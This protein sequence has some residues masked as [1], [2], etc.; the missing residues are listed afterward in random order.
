MKKI[1]FSFFFLMVIT[2]LTAM[3]NSMT[4][5]TSRVSHYPVEVATD[6]ASTP[7]FLC[8]TSDDLYVNQ[9]FADISDVDDFDE[10]A[11]LK[12]DKK[13]CLYRCSFLFRRFSN[14]FFSRK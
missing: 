4:G 3:E 7:R 11:G 10:E 14:T 5:L 6:T 8:E 1:F 12:R 2:S 13:T 9:F